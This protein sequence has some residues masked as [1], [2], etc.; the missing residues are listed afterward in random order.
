V[1]IVF[2]G[3]PEFAVP[4]LGRLT[5]HHNVLAVI[6]QPDRAQGRGRTLSPPPVKV[7]ANELGLDVYQPDTLTD[8]TALALLTRAEVDV[9]VVAAYGKILP[10]E[11]LAIPVHGCINVHASLLPRHRGAAPVHRA[12]LDGDQVTGVSIMLMDEGL[13]TGPVALKRETPVGEKTADELT[14]TLSFIGAEA[15][16]EVLADIH[17]GGVTWVP[18][19]EARATYAEKV[20]PADVAL[21]PDL[22]V[23]QALRRVRASTRSAR[24]KIC[25]DGDV[26]DVLE[27]TS[28][29]CE[30]EPGEVLAEK[31]RLVI[32]LS[33]GDVDLVTVRPSG[34]S[35]MEGACFARGKRLDTGCTW[36]CP[37]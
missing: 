22:T 12:I 27:A 20:T 8:P 4:I 13:D 14:E 1:R 11:V 15:L 19:D 33:D 29:E 24:S 2:M 7:T 35:A 6:T 16:V 21:S 25:I 32:G 30:L 31:S 5:P 34:R 3:T 17:R 26:L 28:C 23:D 9:I 18:Q 10:K 36:E 37:Q